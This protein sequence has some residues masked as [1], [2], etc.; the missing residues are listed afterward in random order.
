MCLW[1]VQ[2]RAKPVNIVSWCI[3]WCI[4]WCCCIT[5]NAQ[6]R[7]DGGSVVQLTHGEEIFWGLWRPHMKSM[8][9]KNPKQTNGNS[10][11]KCLTRATY[12]FFKNK[13]MI[14]VWSATSV[15][16]SQS[17]S[18]SPLDAPFSANTTTLATAS[19]TLVTLSASCARTKEEDIFSC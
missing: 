8:K 11:W 10:G 16:L 6:L 15:G 7:T 18:S 17:S 12:W 2:S 5:G 3:C 19:L 9:K 4:C 13:K 1:A 14:G